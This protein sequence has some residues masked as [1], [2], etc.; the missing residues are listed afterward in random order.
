MVPS[1]SDRSA[2]QSAA[3][4]VVSCLSSP[5]PHPPALDLLV[6]L[7][8]LSSS[9]SFLHGAKRNAGV[10]CH[11]IPIYLYGS[12]KTAHHWRSIEGEKGKK[13]KK[14]WR[15]R[16]KIN[17]RRRKRKRIYTSFPRAV[18]ALGRFFS[19]VRRQ[20]VSPHG[21]KDRCD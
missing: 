10:L 13:K 17:R 15:R 18:L 21:E 4:L 8:P 1:C 7:L 6:L 14:R 2:Y 12:V 19:H 3:G 16:K 5:Y 9:F 11:D 20:N